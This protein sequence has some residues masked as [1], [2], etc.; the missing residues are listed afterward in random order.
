MKKLLLL[1]GILIGTLNF[2]QGGS[3][4]F[5]KKTKEPVVLNS[6]QEIKV[7]D[8]VNIGLGS[9]EDGGFKFVQFL[10]NFNEPSRNADSRISMTKQPIKFF[11]N[12]DGVLYVFTKFYVIN[13]EAALKT[14]EVEFIK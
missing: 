9:K 2:A 11:K 3:I 8:L 5:V 4:S 14:K 12:Q 7:G 13:I 10:N 6:N 1:F